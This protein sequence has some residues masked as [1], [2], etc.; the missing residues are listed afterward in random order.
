MSVLRDELFVSIAES[1]GMEKLNSKVP[2][3][4]APEV[5]YRM[6]EIIDVASKFAQHGKRGKLTSRDIN[7]ALASRNIEVKDLRWIEIYRF[8]RVCMDTV[9]VLILLD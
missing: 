5:E 1:I 8:C 3:V 4:L 9:L 6:R 7:D 2:T